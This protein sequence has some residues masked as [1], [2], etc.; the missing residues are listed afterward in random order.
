MKMPS[1]TIGEDETGTSWIR[2]DV[3]GC[4]LKSYNPNDVKYKYCARC[5]TFLDHE[6]LEQEL[7]DS[8]R[9]V[10]ESGGWRL[11]EGSDP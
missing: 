6:E 7:R 11:A 3:D 4:R 5:D 8:I 9:R 2:H 10:S 1:Y